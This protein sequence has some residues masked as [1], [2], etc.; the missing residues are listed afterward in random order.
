MCWFFQSLSP[1]WVGF[2]LRL[3]ME[4]APCSSSQL[5]THGGKMAATVP[6][7]RTHHHPRKEKTFLLVASM[8]ERGS[9]FQEALEKVFF[10]FGVSDQDEMLQIS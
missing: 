10:W 9:F 4:M 8:E 5:L 2:T 6:D 3:Y 1:S 7:L